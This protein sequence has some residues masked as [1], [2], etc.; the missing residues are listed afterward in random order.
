[1]CTYVHIFVRTYIHLYGEYNNNY[2]DIKYGELNGF[3]LRALLIFIV[4]IYMLSFQ[5]MAGW[6]EFSPAIYIYIHTYI[7][8]Y[9]LA[10]NMASTA[11]KA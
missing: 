8:I 3:W 6:Q 9:M 10:V 5:R 1:M 11:D 4:R 7:Y 2:K